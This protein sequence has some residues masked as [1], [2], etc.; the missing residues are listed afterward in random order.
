MNSYDDIIYNAPT[1]EQHFK[2]SKED[3]AAIKKE[4]REALYA[5]SDKTVKD[6]CCKGDRF[7]QYLDMQAISSRS[8]VNTLLIL[9]QMPQATRLYDYDRWKAQGAYVKSNSI[10]VKI[11]EPQEYTKDD[12]TVGVGY[13]VKRI[14][15]VSQVDT[16]RMKPA[17]PPPKHDERQLLK[18]LVHKAPVSIVS[19]ETMPDHLL[20]GIGAFFDSRENV[21]MVQKGMMFTDIF[22]SVAQELASENLYSSPNEQADRHFSA[23]C[24]SY[25]LCIKYGIDTQG[26]D[27]SEAPEVFSDMDSQTIKGELQQIC[28]AVGNISL[29]ME[30]QLD[31]FQKAEKAQEV[32]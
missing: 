32:R 11:L 27:F 25:L 4:E 9:A 22:Q 20:E 21:I 29:R 13:D 2:M 26:F 8:A 12:G 14:Y 28:D 1:F 3:Y 15:D 10:S 18:A 19:V 24:A 17:A 16:R 30:K 31:S 7:R 5:L 6:V 23:Y